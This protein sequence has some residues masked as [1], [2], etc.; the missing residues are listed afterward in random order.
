VLLETFCETKFLLALVTSLLAELDLV[1]TVE[2]FLL[3]AFCA[4]EVLIFTVPVLGPATSEYG[5]ISV[6]V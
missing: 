1:L 6:V 3:I 5:C 4:G 2:D